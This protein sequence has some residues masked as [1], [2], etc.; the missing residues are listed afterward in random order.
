MSTRIAVIDDEQVILDLL[1]ELLSDE[2][3]EPHVF[4][5]G[6]AAYPRV[7]DLAPAAIILDMRMES[8]TAGWQLLERA[9]QDPVLRT[10]PMIVCSGDIPLLRE[11]AAD[12]QARGC[13][14]LAKPF[15]LADLLDLLDR[16][17]GGPA[18]N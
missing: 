5:D 8:P 16:M 2:G 18:R 4:P 14:L 9:W 1:R 15:D 7:R 3:Y 13:A 12:L 17:T 11:R 10:T 6:A